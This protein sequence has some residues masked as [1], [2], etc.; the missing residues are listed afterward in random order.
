MRD[1]TVKLGY[2]ELEIGAEIQV[3]YCQVSSF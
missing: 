3:A 1:M 2:V